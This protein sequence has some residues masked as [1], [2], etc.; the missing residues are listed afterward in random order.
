[1]LLRSVSASGAE[2]LCLSFLLNIEKTGRLFVSG[3][4]ELASA[5]DDGGEER[6]GASEVGSDGC[7][8]ELK[9]VEFRHIGDA[10]LPGDLAAGIVEG[11]DVASTLS[12]RLR[13]AGGSSSYSGRFIC[14][15]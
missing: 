14:R 3:G 6:A 9:S 10:A 15:E 5:G 8:L 11:V 4:G 12:T 7:G 2:T 1:M 13:L